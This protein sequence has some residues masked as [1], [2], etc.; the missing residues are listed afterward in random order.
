[1]LLKTVFIRSVSAKLNMKK[2][3]TVLILLF[4]KHKNSR[5]SQMWEEKE[6]QELP[7]QHVFNKNF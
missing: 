2:F 3:V 5:Y 7:L 1:M 4:P 6:W